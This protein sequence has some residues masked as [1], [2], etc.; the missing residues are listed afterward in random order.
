VGLALLPVGLALMLVQLLGTLAEAL[1]ELIVD[2]M[3][4]YLGDGK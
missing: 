4:T 3:N 2:Q 1:N